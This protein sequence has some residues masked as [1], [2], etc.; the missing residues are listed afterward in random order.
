MI[1]KQD[2]WGVLFLL[3]LSVAVSFSVNA[4]SP[5]GISFIGQWDRDKG[6]VMAGSNSS[7]A[8]EV[9]QINNPL[10]VKRMV[11]AGDYIIIDVRWPEIYEEGHIPGAVSF[12]LEDIETGK[13]ALK[14]MIQQEDKILVYCAGVTCSDSHTFAEH[15]I[16][17]GFVH[18]AVYAGGFSEWQEMGF[19]VAFE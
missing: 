6:V 7:T 2:L 16:E 19:E 13:Q 14:N 5:E 3:C 17:M 11:D 18:V 10:K 9:I 12:P 8:A 4:V 1:V 15:L